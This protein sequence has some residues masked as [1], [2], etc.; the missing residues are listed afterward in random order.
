MLKFFRFN[1]QLLWEQQ[2]QN[3]YIHFTQV[4]TEIELLP[5]VIKETNKHLH[6]REPTSFNICYLELINLDDQFLIETSDVSGNRPY[7]STNNT[8]KIFSKQFDFNH[9]QQES[10]DIFYSDGNLE[11]F[12]NQKDQ[13]SILQKIQQDVN[14]PQ[15]IP[16][17]TLLKHL[18][19]K[20]FQNL[21]TSLQVTHKALL[22]QTI[23]IYSKFQY[24]L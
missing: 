4:L 3:A 9:L 18:R 15:H 24:I 23:Q 22:L 1:Y 8:P 2:D 11:Q 16:Y 14:L 12:Q 21:L 17:Q 10:Q 13:F 5:Y 19:Y 20:T 6:Y 7:T